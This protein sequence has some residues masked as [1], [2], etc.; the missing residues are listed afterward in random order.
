MET[1]RIPVQ[2]HGRVRTVHISHLSVIF[3]LHMKRKFEA[4]S[5]DQQPSTVGES[6]VPLS[7]IFLDGF[8]Y[9][10][11]GSRGFVVHRHAI[12]SWIS[13]LRHMWMRSSFGMT[14]C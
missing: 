6:Q 4:I 3:F 12:P 13:E 1:K 9:F 11:V 2:Q 5:E 14:K 7:V 8:D 10:G